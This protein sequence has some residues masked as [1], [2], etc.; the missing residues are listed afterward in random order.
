MYH[1]RWRDRGW[2]TAFVY[3]VS[4]KSV[5]IVFRTTFPGLLNIY[6]SRDIKSFSEL[7]GQMLYFMMF[8]LAWFVPSRISFL[9]LDGINFVTSGGRSVG[10]VRSRTQATEFSFSLAL[11]CHAKCVPDHKHM[12]PFGFKVEEM[13]ST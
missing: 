4:R 12:S 8:V 6:I 11:T 5:K 2:S 10:T 7:Y 9:C 13:A 1:T 3:N